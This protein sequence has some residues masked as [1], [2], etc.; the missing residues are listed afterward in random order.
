MQGL[1][2]DYQL[3]TQPLLERARRLFPKKEVVTKAGPNMERSNWGTVAERAGR[4]SN[5]PA[6]L[7]GHPGD[8]G[9]PFAWNHTPPLAPN[10]AI[11]HMRAVLHPANLGLPPDPPASTLQPR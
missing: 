6:R 7:G 1:M 10:F 3:T 2:M 9:A 11:P 5:A 4:L 8:R